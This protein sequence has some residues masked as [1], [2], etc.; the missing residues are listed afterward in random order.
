MRAVLYYLAQ[1]MIGM[2]ILML[3]P[4]AI[5]FT[6]GEDGSALVLVVT[7]ALTAFVSASIILALRDRTRN[8]DRISGYALTV[9][10]WVVP[11]LVAA[12]PLMKMA[13]ATYAIALFEAVSGY[14]T[15]GAT[16][17]PSVEPLGYSGKFFRALL[18]WA[19]G[20]VTLLTIVLVVAPSGLGGVTTTH[21]A[22]VTRNDRRGSQI[23]NTFWVVLSGYGLV[24]LIC[25]AALIAGPIPDFEALCIALSTVSTGGFMPIDGNLGTYDSTFTNIVVSI[26]LLIGATSVVW[27]RMLFEGRWHLLLSHR[28]SY[29]VVAT[30]IAIG[31][32]YALHYFWLPGNIDTGLFGHSFEDGLLTGISLVT[33]A[34]FNSHPDGFALISLPLALLVAF[35]GGGAVSTAGGI[36][37]FRVGAMLSLCVGELARLVYP[38]SVVGARLG[39]IFYDQNLMKSIWSS[40]I[41]SLIV[42]SLATLLISM[43]LPSFDSAFTVAI[44][45]FSNIGPLY[46]SGWEGSEFWPAYSEFGTGAIGVATATMILGR[47][48]VLILLGAL[49]LAYWRS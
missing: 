4:A 42:V 11:P 8:L 44:A 6:V 31:F 43:W 26:F 9:A 23:S 1:V 46:T 41:V 14:T 3:L 15:T 37:F 38:R 47:I 30:G 7:A 49:N 34:G 19:G 5:G 25:L 28:E 22:L 2:S 36:K 12:I 48:E 33:T 35:I 18:Q 29:W 39:R 40:L 17:L 27:H 24:T 13:D 16:A 32:L 21:V 45:A 20:L 10:V